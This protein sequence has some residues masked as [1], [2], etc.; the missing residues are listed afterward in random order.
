MPET[1]LAV[2]NTQALV[3][4]GQA[5]P[6]DQHPA[7]VFIAG[8]GEGSR[9]AQVRAGPRM[10]R[11]GRKCRS[12]RRSR[13]PARRADVPAFADRRAGGHRARE[14]PVRRGETAQALR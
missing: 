4:A 3:A 2:P 7:K 1:Q 10:H 14:R 9:R 8:L 6:P 13:R 11:A 12:P 5:V